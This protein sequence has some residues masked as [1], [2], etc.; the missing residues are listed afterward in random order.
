MV[1]FNNQ[2]QVVGE[3]F[4]LK[5]KEKE[6]RLNCKSLVPLHLTWRNLNNANIGQDT[7]LCIVVPS[8]SP[9]FD[10]DVVVINGNKKITNMIHV[11]NALHP[12]SSTP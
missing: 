1:V 7:Y 2:A 3:I 10:I 12:V 4:W 9:Y 8:H 5:L 11:E 6:R